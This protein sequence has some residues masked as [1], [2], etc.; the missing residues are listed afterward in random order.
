V[1]RD[2]ALWQ[3]NPFTNRIWAVTCLL[4]V[5]FHGVIYALQLV[6]EDF[7]GQLPNLWVALLVL[8]GGSLLSMIVSELAKFQENKWVVTAYFGMQLLIVYLS[9]FLGSTRA[10]NV[11]RVLTLAPNWA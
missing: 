11:G 10:I 4:L 5:L 7:W 8:F 3:R 9:L 1:H 6:L 2:H